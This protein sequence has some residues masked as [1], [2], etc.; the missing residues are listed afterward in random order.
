TSTT[1]STSST[2]STST[3]TSSTT[4]MAQCLLDVDRN[5][6]LQYSTDVVYIQRHL[7]GGGLDTVPASFRRIDPTIPPD[8]TINANIDAVRSSLDVDMN[9][10]TDYA[11]DVV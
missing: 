8:S 10:T 5:G 4:T 11:T 6:T 3:S 1:S 2:T 9:G 7:I